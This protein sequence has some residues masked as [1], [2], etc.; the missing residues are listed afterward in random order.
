MGTQGTFNYRGGKS[1]LADWLIENTPRADFFVDPFGGS[2]AVSLSAVRSRK[3]GQILY[4]DKD[5]FIFTTLSVIRDNAGELCEFLRQTPIGRETVNLIY[6]WKNSGD[7]LK[8]AAGCI[9]Q[10]EFTTY[11]PTLHNNEKNGWGRPHIRHINSISR[12]VSSWLA[13]IENIRGMQND[14]LQM[15][16]ENRDWYDV[17]KRY[18]KFAP[19]QLKPK[20]PLH[21]IFLDPPYGETR[22]Y[23]EDVPPEAVYNFFKEDHPYTYKMLCDVEGIDE[24]TGWEFVEFPHKQ[25]SK[26]GLFLHGIYINDN[27]FRTKEP[28]GLF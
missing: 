12:G 1:Q 7:P 21:I 10:L 5:A 17:A 8:I 26:K 22:G 15:A 19:S 6:E 28:E 27:S 25:T 4:N 3:F 14:L 24:L 13:R 23:N 9:I 16:L 20:T 18:T 2:G 11:T